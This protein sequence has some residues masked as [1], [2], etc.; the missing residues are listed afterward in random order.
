MLT[1]KGKYGLKAMLA[2]TAPSA[3]RPL[4]ADLAEIKTLLEAH[5]DHTGS[6]VSAGILDR[7]VEESGSFWV[8]SASS[9]PRPRILTQV[10]EIPTA[11]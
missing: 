8:I 4:D 10:T 3:R 6:P 9:R 2:D 5:R 1:N 7:W 11:G